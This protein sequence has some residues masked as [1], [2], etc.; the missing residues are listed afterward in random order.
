MR[1]RQAGHLLAAVG[2][3]SAQNDLP[4]ILPNGDWQLEIS[5]GHGRLHPNV[6]LALTV[7]LAALTGREDSTAPTAAEASAATQLPAAVTS[8][9]PEM[10]AVYG[11]AE[12]VAKGSVSVL[13]C[14]ESGTGKEL[15]AHWIHQQS[16]RQQGPSLAINCAALPAELLEAE[17]FS[18]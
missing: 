12:R 17:I 4:A 15:L 14:G 16:P 5:P 10:L 1:H 9:S 18:I 8:S 13:I 3:H 6:R 7:G 11:L 2:D